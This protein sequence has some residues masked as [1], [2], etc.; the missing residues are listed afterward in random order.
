MLIKGYRLSN[1]TVIEIG[2]FAILWN[3]FERDY[4][5]NNCNPAKIKRVCQR[6]SI[7]QESQKILAE[8]LNTR[9]G[10]FGQIIPEYV[11]TGLYPGAARRTGSINDDCIGVLVVAQHDIFAFD[12]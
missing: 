9:R 3:C 6:L 1:E 8:V 10:W 12:A 7:S 2:K 11:E 5:D 4:C